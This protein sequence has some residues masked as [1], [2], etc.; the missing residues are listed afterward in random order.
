[1]VGRDAASPIASASLRLFLPRL[2]ER[3]D[4]LRRDQPHRMAQ[5]LRNPAPV[6]G[7][8]ARFQ[9]HLG[10]RGLGQER[11]EPS[12]GQVLAQDRATVLI[13]PVQGENGLGRVNGNALKL[14]GGRL[15]YWML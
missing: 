3:L 4:V 7:A 2:C 8:A 5:L 6:V 1:M 10:G 13:H 15:L 14:H 12:P 11:L 9:H